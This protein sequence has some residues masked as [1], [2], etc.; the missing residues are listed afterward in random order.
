M[1]ITASSDGTP[2]PAAAVP[3]MPYR[4][5]PPQEVRLES[6]LFQQR[7]DLNTAYLRSL[8]NENLLR[9]Y[10]SEAGIGDHQA[11]GLRQTFHGDP[12]QGDDWHWGWETP[13]H[14]LRGHFLGHWLSG[15]ARV[16]AATGDADLAE[17]VTTI[18]SELA[19]CQEENGG[20]WVFAIP[21]KFLDLIARGKKIWAP[22]YVVHKTFLGLVDTYRYTGNR[23]ALEVAHR[24]G[25]WFHRWS[26]A[27]DR[28]QMDDILDHETGGVLEIWADLY[29]ET[30]DP[31]YLDLMERYDRRRL[32][33][34]L[35]AG[36]DMLSLVHA[37]ST[38]PEVLGAA[39]AYEVT[40]DPRW[41]DI[42]E[43]YWRCAVTDRGFFATGGQTS[44][45][46][47]TPPFELA[48]HRSVHNQEH[49]TVYNMIRLADAMFR[50]TGDVAHLDYI[51]RNIYNGILAQQ[52]PRTGMI[53]YYLSF[54]GGNVKRW[55]HPTHDFWCC[56]GTLVQA[57]SRH[58]AYVYYVG[59]GPELVV[60]Q[61]IP[62]TLETRLVDAAGDVDLHVGMTI[63]GAGLEY[64][65]VTPP[66]AL[67]RPEGWTVT[68]RIRTSRPVQARLRLRAPRWL[69]GPVTV[70]V[71][72]ETVD[73]VAADGFIVLDRTWND[74]VVLLE[75]PTNLWTEPLPDE[76]STVA[77][78][79]GPIVL[80]AVTDDEPVLLGDPAHPESI[81]RRDGALFGGFRATSPDRTIRFHRFYEIADEP[82]SIYFPVR[83]S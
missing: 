83:P 23:Q 22:Q 61:Y 74:D 36:V 56:H 77:F 37:N 32:F 1:T 6:G 47:W 53:S 40:G 71:G 38:I 55:G 21:S 17:R 72:G 48:A 2:V 16:V 33:D 3:S 79:H 13:G 54:Q 42:V 76:P 80:A 69:A 67:D 7:A 65:S 63:A 10:Y 81:L 44:W 28:T 20:E 82:F 70:T 18:V 50:V 68:L 49:C 31:I 14:Q 57:Q 78:L 26:A 73:A 24:A 66:V 25:Q 8:T 39:R 62:S 4:A 30:R 43:A 58:N 11:P 52:H 29:G 75:L 41:R 51:E 9:H 45:E 59:D 35:V 19:R 46:Y 12:G 27:F 60:A 34:P 15:A 5:L 64:V